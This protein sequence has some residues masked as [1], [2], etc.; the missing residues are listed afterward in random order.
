VKTL[1]R[2]LPPFIKSWRQFYALVMAWLVVLIFVF[3]LITKH[4]E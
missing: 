3:W 4:F 2:D 1:D